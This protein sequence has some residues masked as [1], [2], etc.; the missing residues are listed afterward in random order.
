MLAAVLSVQVGAAVA[1]ELFPTVGAAGSVFLRLS[2]AAVVMVAVARPRRSQF[3]RRTLRYALTLGAVLALMNLLFYLSLTRLPL[4]PAVTIE[5]MGPLLLAVLRS[6]RTLDFVWAAVAGAGVLGVAWGASS[7]AGLDTLGVLLSIAA[8]GCWASYI[9]LSQRVGHEL[10]GVTGLSV[11]LVFAALLSAPLGI[12]TA[13]ADLLD[14]HVLVMGIAVGV[15][16]AALP[17]GLEM[18]ALRR[19]PAQQFS[20]LMSLQPAAAALAG[21]VV[22]GET[23]THMQSAGIALVCLASAGTALSRAPSSR[24]APTAV[25]RAARHTRTEQPGPRWSR[26]PTGNRVV[27]WGTRCLAFGVREGVPSFEVRLK[28]PPQTAHRKESRWVGSR[29]G[30]YASLGSHCSPGS[31]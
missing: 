27:L 23:L 8:G 3:N 21:L 16:S 1:K 24:G 29:S 22:L 13:G 30:P 17:W 5:F 12:H 2:V 18:H 19:M 9:L 25:P 4:G 7:L 6:R 14:R 11:A 26:S 10:P 31:C 20:V 15:L 28:K